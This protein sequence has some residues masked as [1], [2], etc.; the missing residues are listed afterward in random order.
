MGDRVLDVKI[1][2]ENIVNF[3]YRTSIVISISVLIILCGEIIIRESYLEIYKYIYGSKQTFILSIALIFSILVFLYSIFNNIGISTIIVGTS[4]IILQTINY[5]KYIFKGEYLG[6]YDIKLLNEALTISSEF[7]IHPTS[8]MVWAIM[9]IIW[10]SIITVY[11][12]EK[13]IS[14]KKR[15]CFGITFIISVLIICNVIKSDYISDKIG[16]SLTKFNTNDNYENNGFIFTFINRLNKLEIEEPL[17]YSKES[18]LKILNTTGLV[19]KEDINIKP[20]I[21]IIMNESFSDVMDLTNMYLSEDPIP[22]FRQLKNNF[23]GGKVIT[24]VIGGFTAQVEY[25]VLTGNFTFFTNVNNIAY[26]EYIYEDFPSLVR[27]LND[28][29]YNSIA[30]HPYNRDFYSRD[31][32]YKNL[33]FKKYIAEDNFLD[34][35][36]IRT[37]ITDMEVYKRI[38]YEYEGNKEEKPLFMHVVTMQNHGPY[39]SKYNDYNINIESSYLDESNKTIMLE[40]SNLL[41]KSDEALKY[42]IEYFEEVDEPTIVLV[43]GDHRPVLGDNLSSYK[44]LNIVN[45]HLDY[46]QYHKIMNTPFAIWNNYQLNNLKYDNIDSTYLGAILLK[47]ADLNYDTYFNYLYNNLCNIQALNE[48]FYIDKQGTVKS[49]SDMSIETKEI[50]KNLWLLQY[51]RSFGNKYIDKVVE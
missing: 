22:Y 44:Q 26:L 49:N 34:P 7:E 5:Y 45:E 50:L 47:M 32:V 42:L 41:K 6:P 28:I 46:R 24:P 10:L 1:K 39:S 48:Y 8:N 2:K 15:I 25:Q 20:N 30:I 18:V 11:T 27:V 35:E 51:D 38:I 33:G 14:K 19:D 36:R 21:I 31:N 29:G 13:V 16:I 23:T 40:Y 3:I 12:N 37:Y 9:C 4:Y 17:D 43:F